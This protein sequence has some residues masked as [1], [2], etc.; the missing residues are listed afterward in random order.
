MEK[1]IILFTIQPNN[2][3][4]LLLRLSHNK[5]SEIL[6]SDVAVKFLKER[7]KHILETKPAHSEEL[8]RIM[9]LFVN[10]SYTTF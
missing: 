1:L 4:N 7:L 2:V 9:T 3:L 10:S 8:Q 6:K 5:I